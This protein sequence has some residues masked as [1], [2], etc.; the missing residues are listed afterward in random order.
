MAY[1]WDILNVLRDLLVDP[2]IRTDLRAKMGKEEKSRKATK[3]IIFT[4]MHV[5]G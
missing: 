4:T 5:D 1:F 3:R 2:A